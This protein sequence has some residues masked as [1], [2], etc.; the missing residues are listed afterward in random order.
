MTNA[1]R[2][3]LAAVGLGLWAGCQS[4]AATVDTSQA[5]LVAN[6][7]QVTGTLGFDFLPPI[8]RQLPPHFDGVFAA[9][10]S[11]TVVIDQV[12]LPSGQTLANVA[13]LTATDRKVRR[14][15]W[16]EFY[17]AR[18][19]TSGLD[20]QSH[21]RI[22]VMLDDKELGAADLGVAAS[23]SDLKSVDASKVT[24][25]V[26]GTTLPIKFRIERKAADQD[27]DG[28]PDWRD[29][30][31]T[32]Y[33]PP[34]A[35]PPLPGKPVTPARCDYN[36]SDCDPQELDCLPM[37]HLQQPTSA[38]APATAATAPCPTPATPPACATPPRARAGSSPCPTRHR[39]PTGTPAT[40]PRPVRAASAPPGR[41]RPAGPARTPVSPPAAIRSTGAGRPPSRTGRPGRCQTETAFDRVE[42][43][44]RR[45]APAGSRTATA[46]RA[47][48]AS[49]T[50]R[51]TSRIA[52][53]AAPP[54]RP[55]AR[56]PS[57]RRPGSRAPAPGG[58]WTARWPSPATGQP[59][60]SS[61]ARRSASRVAA[62]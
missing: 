44:A 46:T 40:G 7:A 14:H 19:D 8:S 57:S 1:S 31:P 5:S 36:K 58:R 22:R 20:P 28:V 15:P 61:S 49:V 18:F 6:R 30:C 17:I 59:A 42:P 27:G 2:F 50:C 37:R 13:T 56:R 16:R 38:R 23:A 35:V 34:V 11:P 62:C 21:Y 54:A 43:A 26:A 33:N 3:A 29:N 48:G 55:L 24:P 53:R 60:T 39:A 25:V 4:P 41:R 32:I 10:L 45:P 47:T 52:A 51:P 9:D 12:Q